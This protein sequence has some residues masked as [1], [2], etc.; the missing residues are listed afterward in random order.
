VVDSA[1]TTRVFLGSDNLKE[2]IMPDN[3]QDRGPRDRGRIG[4]DEEWERR[5]WAKELGVSEDTL[6]KAVQKVG[7]SVEAVRKELKSA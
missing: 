4:L 7:V 1:V 6:R 2:G 3:L 5:Y